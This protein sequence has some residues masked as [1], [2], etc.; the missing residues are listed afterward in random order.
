MGPRIRFRRTLTVSTVL[1]LL[2]VGL[3]VG[4]TQIAGIAGLGSGD[5]EERVPVV[6]V[7]DGDTIHVRLGGRE[8]TVRYIGVNT[9]ETVDPRRA[10][11]RFGKEASERNRQLVEGK[12]VTL[13]KDVSHTDRFGRLLRYVYVDGRM[14]NAAL[15]EEGYAHASAFPPD[16]KYRDLFTRL[17]REARS[18][19]RGLWTSQ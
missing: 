9:P 18:A 14:V 19:K 10:V 16:V 4:I 11:E 17:E 5:G 12:T 3:A 15:V 1:A 2:A 13:E 7:V 8:Q 6:R